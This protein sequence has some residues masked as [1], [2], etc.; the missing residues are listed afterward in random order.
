MDKQCQE[1]LENIKKYLT[2]PPLLAT[3][4]GKIPGAI[5][6]PL[7]ITLLVHY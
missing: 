3:Y 2:V 4:Q 1:T 7:W 5:H 6:H